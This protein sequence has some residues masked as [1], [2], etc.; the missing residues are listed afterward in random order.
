MMTYS[1]VS[2]TLIRFKYYFAWKLNSCSVHACGISYSGSSLD[3]ELKH[4][5]LFKKH[6][7]VNIRI[8]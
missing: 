3:S 7:N 2:V 1:F 6:S 8:V 5:D 4:I